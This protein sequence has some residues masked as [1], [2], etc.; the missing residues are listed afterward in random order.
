[1]FLAEPIR[2]LLLQ[3]DIPAAAT[4]VAALVLPV[5]LHKLFEKNELLG[6]MFLGQRMP[7]AVSSL[8]PGIA[9]RQ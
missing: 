4:I 1:M 2:R 9:S 6:R 3:A 7:R 8:Q 5:I